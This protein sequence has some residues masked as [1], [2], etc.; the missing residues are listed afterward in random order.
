MTTQQSSLVKP[1]NRS[2]GPRTAGGKAIS[3]RNAIAHGL[4]SQEAVVLGER[5]KDWEAFRSGIF[6]S[7]S[8]VGTLEEVLAEQLAAIAWRMRRVLRYESGVMSGRIS[9]DGRPTDETDCDRTP[10]RSRQIVLSD[11]KTARRQMDEFP[12]LIEGY[13]RLQSAS[14][15]EP[16]DA[17]QAFMLLDQAS[18]IMSRAGHDKLRFAATNGDFL[19]EIGIPAEWRNRLELWDQWTAG[20]LM[21]AMTFFGISYSIDAPTVIVRVIEKI[22]TFMDAQ[23]DV[24]RSLEAEWNALPPIAEN[25]AEAEELVDHD[26][27]M[28]ATM[29]N[30][31]IRY[32]GHLRRELNNAMDTLNRLQTNRRLTVSATEDE[33]PA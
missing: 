12:R 14:A 6:A 25:S 10:G 8:P 1:D 11:L 33:D 20:T 21:K 9:S 13:R 31:V 27:I 26:P 2:G 17:R 4:G 3:K 15:N 7:I 16:F 29:L 23:S 18:D 32:G 22:T 19:S 24:V 5:K 28:D 30:N